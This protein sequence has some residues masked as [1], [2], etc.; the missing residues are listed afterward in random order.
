MAINLGPSPNHRSSVNLLLNTQTGT[1]SPQFHVKYDD[2]FDTTRRDWT[3]RLP[4]CLWRE[5]N[6]FLSSP[7]E[8]QQ[9][10]TPTTV[11]DNVGPT[12]TITREAPS[13]LA[14]PADNRD[15]TGIPQTVMTVN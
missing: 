7:L 15:E 6:H 3:T 9:V 4:K 2:H 5:K 10:S 11:Q 12:T 13:T 8:K 14:P 1:V